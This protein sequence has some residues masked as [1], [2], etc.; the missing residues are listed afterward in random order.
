MC[1]SPLGTLL[2]GAKCNLPG[3]IQTV[4]R[5]EIYALVLLV[6]FADPLAELDY[7]TDNKGL[8]NAF[9]QGPEYCQNAAN[10]DLYNVILKV[11]IDKAIRL[12]VRWMPSHL[13]EKPCKGVFSGVSNLGI[14]GNDHADKL[15]VDAARRACVPLNV[16]APILYYR[17]LLRKI[18]YRLATILINLPNRKKEG[19]DASRVVPPLSVADSVRFERCSVRLLTGL[20][21]FEDSDARAC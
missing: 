10:C 18:Q 8:F 14:L 7:V 1:Y 4:P 5:G 9:R 15:T 17:S 13:L 16:S 21:N 19:A 12:S 3:E 20:R 6:I 11:T 2:F